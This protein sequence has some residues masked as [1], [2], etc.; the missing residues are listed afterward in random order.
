MLAMGDWTGGMSR[1][2]RGRASG[3]AQ[4]IQRHDQQLQ[5]RLCLLLME[6]SCPGHLSGEDPAMCACL[7]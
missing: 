3:C 6:K 4:H 5:Q 1:R 2:Q 7:Q